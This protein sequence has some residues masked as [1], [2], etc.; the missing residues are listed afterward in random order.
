[1]IPRCA[2][3]VLALAAAAAPVAAQVSPGPLSR[4][5]RS[6]EGNAGCFGCHGSRADALQERCLSCHAG[7]RAL[8]LAGRG[9]HA[10]EGSG[11]CATCHPEHAGADFALIAWPDGGPED[12]DHRRAGF[13]LD[14]KHAAL[15][16]R[17]CHQPRFQR[18]RRDPARRF[19]GLAPAC[20]SCHADPHAGRLGS[21]CARCHG[22]ADWKSTPGFDHARTAYPLRGKHATLACAPCHRREGAPRPVYA[23]LPHRECSDCHADPHARRLGADCSRCHV[24]TGFRQVTKGEFDHDR[25]R[26]PLRGAHGTVACARCHDR[27]ARPP[28]AA[29]AGCHADPHRGRATL[30][31]KAPDCGACH[32]LRAFRPA[33]LAAALHAAFPLEGK[34]A[35]V[36]CARCHPTG[37][38]GVTFRPPHARCADCH[39]DPHAFTPAL[40]CEPC[41]RVAGWTPSTVGAA[42]HAAYRLKLEGA[43]ASAPCTSCHRPPPKRELALRGLPLA[44]AACHRDVH[45]FAPARDCAACHDAR[46][47]APGRIGPADHAAFAY[48]LEGAHAAVPCS[49]CHADLLGPRPRLAVS[50]RDSRRECAACHQDPHRPSLGTACGSCHDPSAFRPARRFDHDRD[51]RFRLGPAHAPLACAACHGEGRW[52]G[53]PSRCEA[54]HGGKRV[55]GGPP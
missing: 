25:T 22:A 40:S 37:A 33:V 10:R 23:P 47:F 17:D 4:A 54:C 31:G 44:C 38:Q 9:L 49:G 11:A 34:H 35:G 55:S 29:C 45:A 19:L 6:L 14:G 2:P 30:V 41:H 27:A 53:V 15:P 16:C 8:R 5:H 52:R 13:V 50:F 42:E 26:Y 3:L 32:T 20:G 28:F 48:P 18:D 39:R 1:L 24:E 43:H 7:V 51:T 21:A 46:S 36:A 12:F